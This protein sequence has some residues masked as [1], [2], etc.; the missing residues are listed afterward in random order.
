MPDF[1]ANG[2]LIM[3]IVNVTPDSFSD[4][5]CFFDTENAVAH[6]LRLR[7]EGADILDI[8]GESTRPGSVPVS[9][10]EEMDRVLPV[11]ERLQGCGALLSVDTRHADTMRAALDIGVDIVNDVS[12]LS[13]DPESLGVVAGGAVR[14]VLMHMKGDPRGMQDAPVYEDV[15]SEVYDY[16]AARIAVCEAAGIARER[17]IC[18]PG[19]GFGK[20]LEHNLSLLKYI[21]KFSDLGVTVL[22]GVSRKRFIEAVMGRAGVSAS[23]E[24]RLPGSLAA[25]LWGLSQ[26]VGI[27]RVHDVAETRQAL[28]VYQ[29]I[30]SMDKS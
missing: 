10:A 15:V 7:D 24:S 6:A 9:A 29:S 26:G 19:I 25:A 12:A 8:G 5:G 23:V 2:P 22:L 18:D 14:V 4:G 21:G 13:H 28:A 30:S 27:F 11:L 16:L 1:A 17:I 20:A 3:G